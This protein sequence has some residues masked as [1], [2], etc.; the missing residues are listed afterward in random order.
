M[1]QPVSAPV[2]PQAPVDMGQQPIAPAQAPG[3][4]PVAAPPGQAPVA[5]PPVQAPGQ[6][7]VDMGQQ[8][9]APAQAPGQAPVAQPPMQAPPVAAPPVQQPAGTGTEPLGQ[10]A[11]QPVGAAPS[12]VSAGTLST[13]LAVTLTSGTNLG[14]TQFSSGQQVSVISVPSDLSIPQSG[15]FTIPTGAVVSGPGMSSQFTLQSPLTVSTG[16]NGQAGMSG[17]GT[18][19]TNPMSVPSGMLATPLAGSINQQLNLGGQSFNT[20]T[21]ISVVGVPTDLTFPET[22]VV[23]LPSGTMVNIPSMAEMGTF[24]LQTP[25]NVSLSGET[26]T[27]L[28]G[29]L[30]VPSVPNIPGM[31]TE[32]MNIPSEMMT[33]ISAMFTS[34]FSVGG[35]T[36]T[37]Q[38]LSIIGLPT[39]VSLPESGRF[40]LPTGSIVSF[41]GM[42]ELGAISLENPLAINLTGGAAF[43]PMTGSQIPAGSFMLTSPLGLTLPQQL[44]LGGMQFQPGQEFVLLGLPMGA[45]FP[46]MGMGMI[47]QG[48][49]LGIP[50][51]PENQFILEAPMMGNVT[52]AAPML[53]PGQASFETAPGISPAREAISPSIPPAAPVA[54]APAQRN[55]V[56]GISVPSQPAQ[57]PAISQGVTTLPR[58]GGAPIPLTAAA[59]AMLSGLMLWA[60]SFA[61][62]RRP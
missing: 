47:P 14:G 57:Q 28:T 17:T 37:P 27:T 43:A 10:P 25:L 42:P 62:P 22:G 36:I 51:Q 35:S 58:T 33:G 56:A 45:E 40:T 2:A 55:E 23:T 21:Q 31:T 6:A 38:E 24:T 9:I 13:P 59:V 4:A 1:T 12:Q 60:I 49:I 32:M 52:G 54:A 7:L 30:G 8:P 50:G 18:V 26:S 48:A 16:V 15:S 3:Q 11:Q 41:P 29:N 19:G 20:G 5:A 53:A 34:P 44:T 46:Q 39:N 61:R